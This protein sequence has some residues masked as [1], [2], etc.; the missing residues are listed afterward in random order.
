MPPSDP[1]FFTNET[2]AGHH[3]RDRLFFS[4]KGRCPSNCFIYT[5]VLMKTRFA[6]SV[7]WLGSPAKPQRKR[8]PCRPSATDLG[9]LELIPL[10]MCSASGESENPKGDETRPASTSFR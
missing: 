7:I 6:L 9:P 2:Y 4:T 3:S 8:F 1:N 10:E 5:I